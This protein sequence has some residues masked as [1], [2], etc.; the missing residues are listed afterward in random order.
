[1]LVAMA[2]VRNLGSRVMRSPSRPGVGEVQVNP[3]TGAR[4]AVPSGREISCTKEFLAGSLSRT[5]AI[6][7]R[8]F[9]RTWLLP[10]VDVVAVKL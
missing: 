7:R 8:R 6:A 2:V 3:F 5:S 9:T 1:M 4:P 10:N